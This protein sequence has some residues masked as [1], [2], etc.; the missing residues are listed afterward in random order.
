MKSNIHIYKLLQVF[1]EENKWELIVENDH[2]DTDIL[3][4]YDCLIVATNLKRKQEVMV[5]TLIIRRE[6]E[7]YDVNGK[8][9]S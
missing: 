1:H 7:C 8:V 3:C 5:T 4:T 2:S 9:T 6:S